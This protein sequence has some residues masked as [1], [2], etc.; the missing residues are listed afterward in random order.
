MLTATINIDFDEVNNRKSFYQVKSDNVSTNMSFTSTQSSS[1]IIFVNTPPSV[2]ND[3]ASTKE[4]IS[5]TVNVLANDTDVNNDILTVTSVTQG[6][7]GAAV[8]NSNMTV[9]YTPAP[10]Y[11]GKD[12]FTYTV[13]D[14]KGGVSVGNVTIDIAAITAVVSGQA[15]LE[16]IPWEGWQS[17]TKN[18]SDIELT[19]IS[20]SSNSI[21]S[22]AI[23][24]E[25][26]NFTFPD[27]ISKGKYN[28]LGYKSGYLRA[29]MG[30]IEVMSDSPLF[31]DNLL[32]LTGDIEVDNIIDSKDLI[33]MQSV[34]GTVTGTAAFDMQYD[35]DGNKK[36][37][38][39]DLIYLARNFK[40]TGYSQVVG[41]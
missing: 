5:V 11:I 1:Y 3:T 4:G 24:D 31:A 12:T 33:T 7:N 8:V 36:I 26:G 35:L 2:T 29:L 27:N 9:T 15:K 13:S 25:N 38:I 18:H 30:N 22:T 14:G 19:L 32:L 39:N 28:L 20:Q 40:K 34:Y 23:S 10:G 6:T 41:Q 21:V 37:N 17:T 16:A